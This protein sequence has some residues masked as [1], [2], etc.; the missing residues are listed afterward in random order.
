VFAISVS[1]V[2]VKASCSEVSFRSADDSTQLSAQLCMP[3]VQSALPAVVD[4]RPRTCEGPA[5]IPP[6]WEETVLPS[7]GY[8]VLAIDSVAARDLG[9]A[10]RDDF[11]VLGSRQIVGDAYGALQFLSLDRRFDGRRV[12]L[13]GFGAG[14]ATA[15]IFA[16]TTEAR[17]V[18]SSKQASAFASFFAISPY[19]NLRF[20]RAAA[21]LVRARP[22]LCGR[23]GR[24]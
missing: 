2:L 1:A 11:K 12:A 10:A 20:G 22:N 6:G 4:L 21:S 24:L 9:P 14:I 13:I 23:E 3:S 7:W 5:G 17:D 15:V 8:A 19:C 18:F 16:D